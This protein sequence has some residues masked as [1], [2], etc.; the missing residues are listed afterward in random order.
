MGNAII[1]ALDL[2]RVSSQYGTISFRE[3]LNH[4]KFARFGEMFL[5]CV[6]FFSQEKKQHEQRQGDH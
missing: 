4:W 2:D 5:R 6:S 3:S 1:H